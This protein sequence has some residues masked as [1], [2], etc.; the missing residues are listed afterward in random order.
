MAAAAAE[1]A[2]AGVAP[3]TVAGER[4]V[5]GAPFIVAGDAATQRGKRKECTSE[6][7]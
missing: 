6:K 7:Q 4:T 3:G 5:G 1:T 2:W